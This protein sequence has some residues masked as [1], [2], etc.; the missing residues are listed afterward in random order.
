MKFTIKNADLQWLKMITKNV[1]SVTIPLFIM[2]V[3]LNET[4]LLQAGAI[5]F[6]LFLILSIPAFIQIN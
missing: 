1:N 2:G 4:V 3:F 5:C 6:V